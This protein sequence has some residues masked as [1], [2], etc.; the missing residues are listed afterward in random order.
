MSTAFVL[1]ALQLTALTIRTRIAA[2]ANMSNHTSQEKGLCGRSSVDVGFMFARATIMTLNSSRINIS[3]RFL[4]IPLL[5]SSL[6]NLS[7]TALAARK[8]LVEIKLWQ[9]PIC[10]DV[11]KLAVVGRH[12]RR[13]VPLLNRSEAQNSLSLA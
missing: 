12:R 7:L 1:E 5:V 6:P 8:W 11:R 4:T 9:A 10:V 2:T 3:L 13:M